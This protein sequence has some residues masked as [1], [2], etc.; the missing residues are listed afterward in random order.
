MTGSV[1]L[2]AVAL[3]FGLTCFPAVPP[4]HAQETSYQGRT[5]AEWR[6]DLR[7]VEPMTREHAVDALARFGDPAVPILTE[8]I[9]D[10]DFNVRTLAMFS[11]GR[12]GAQAKSALPKLVE[13]LSDRDQVIRLYAAGAMRMMGPAAAQAASDVARVAVADSSPEVRNMAAGA[14]QSMGA[15]VKDVSDRLLRQFAATDPDEAVRSR[16][17]ELLNQIR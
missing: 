15:G 4:A 10:P 3:L 14:L 8:A 17:T 7:S 13:K 6:D 2:G 5:L 16:A 11:L 1:R 12:M 9:A